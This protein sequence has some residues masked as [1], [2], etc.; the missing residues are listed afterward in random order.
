MTAPVAAPPRC[1][2]CGAGDPALLASLDRPPA[3]EKDYGVA[4]GQYRRSIYQCRECGLYLN[5]HA[6]LSP[7]YYTGDYNQ[8]SWQR[9]FL[10]PF[11]RILSLPDDQSDN[12]RRVARVLAFMRRR[13]LDPAEAD[14]LDVGSGLC[15][16]LAELGR[17]GCRCVCVDPDPA[18]VRH[19]REHA[20][21]EWGHAGTLDTFP[22]THRFD[23]VA[24]NKVLEHVPDPLRLLEQGRRL[25]APGGFLYV[26]LPDGDLAREHGD[27]THRQEFFAEHCAVYHPEAVRRLASLARLEVLELGRLHEPSG[28]CTVFAFLEPARHVVPP[29]HGP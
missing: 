12:R 1:P 3:G 8:A 11:T 7:D 13:E 21:V 6:L 23:V 28:K 5:A 25:L 16:F 22:D 20:G 9:D 4:P 15:V 27:L 18:A 29:P 2:L 24:F 17:H 10:T 14:V 26:E 19:A